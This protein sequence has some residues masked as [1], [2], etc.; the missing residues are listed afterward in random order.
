MARIV[1]SPCGFVARKSAEGGA[2]APSRGF[3]AATD[4]Q[5]DTRR[6][7]RESGLTALLDWQIARLSAALAPCQTAFPPLSRPR[8]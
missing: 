7:G 8:H 2:L 5:G 1:M 3:D 4:L 6:A